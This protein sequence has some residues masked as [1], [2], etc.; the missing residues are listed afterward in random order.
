MLERDD[1]RQG[2]LEDK[3]DV[4]EDQIGDV[5]RELGVSPAEPEAGE[6][7]SEE[8]LNAKRALLASKKMVR[9]AIARLRDD[10]SGRAEAE[11]ALEQLAERHERLERDHETALES[12]STSDKDRSELARSIGSIQ[13]AGEE[14][15][16]ELSRRLDAAEGRAAAAEEEAVGLR[17]RLTDADRERG[18]LED[19][20]AASR[21]ACERHEGAAD[22]LR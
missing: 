12:I 16:A 8:Y 1:A 10:A 2:S 17:R 18:R 21:E 5:H 11:R 6:N 7:E 14:R 13:R 15:E 3:V 20:L 22:E 9:A 4:L 19:A